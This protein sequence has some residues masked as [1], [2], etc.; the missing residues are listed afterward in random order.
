M[1][2][3]DTAEPGL[4]C[5]RA[6]LRTNGTLLWGQHWT[7]AQVR[8]E[9][10]TGHAQGSDGTE[11]RQMWVRQGGSAGAGREQGEGTAGAH[12]CYGSGGEGEERM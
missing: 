3:L 2:V 4:E 6:W 11:A 10:E 12:D 8:A 9:G 5:W 1:G 7:R